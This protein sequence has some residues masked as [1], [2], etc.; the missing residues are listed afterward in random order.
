MPL[1]TTTTI[2]AMIPEVWSAY[3]VDTREAELVW[4]N[5]YDRQF[6]SE[7]SGRP[8]DTVHLQ[9]VNTFQNEA[10]VHALTLGVG[11]TLT[12]TE[13]RTNAQINLLINTHAYQAF[14]LETEAELL[15]N[16]NALEKY[17]RYAAYAVA[18]RLDDD[19]AGFP[20]DFSNAVGALGATLDDAD[21]LRGAQYLDDI[22]APHTERYFVF[23]HAQN[24]EFRK[25]EKYINADYKQAV[26]S[27][28]TA[29]MRGKVATLY[30]LEWYANDNVEGTNTAGHDNGIFHKSAV[31]VCVIDNMRVASQYEIDTDSMKYAVHIL[32]GAIEVRDN[33]GVF[34]RGL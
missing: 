18:H 33:H 5:L 4:V 1:T 14:D 10:D 19:M 23:S 6:E 30:G 2:D 22:F 15:T 29:M 8:Y 25:V 21:V 31:A 32:Y 12:Y 17:S 34:M 9:G 7:F 28:D 20:D 16:I 3:T 13:G 27:M 26:G 24:R 11:G